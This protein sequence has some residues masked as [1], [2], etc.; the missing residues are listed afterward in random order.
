M[1]CPE[2]GNHPVVTVFR[3]KIDIKCCCEAFRSNLIKKSEKLIAD[4]AKK[5][6][7]DSLKKMFK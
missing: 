5:E 4:I 1:S 6:I 3:D 7:E 2:H